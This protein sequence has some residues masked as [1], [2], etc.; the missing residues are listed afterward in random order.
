MHYFTTDRVDLAAALMTL[1]VMPTE[2]NGMG[3]MMDG[4]R[5][6]CVFNFDAAAKACNGMNPGEI[7]GLWCNWQ[8]FK[9]WEA[10]NPE[11]PL[12]YLRVASHN[13][14]RV[15]DWVKQSKLTH[16]IRKPDGKVFLVT[17]K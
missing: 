14:E 15:L 11:D 2:G 9:E 17:E 12:A 3:R 4:G 5:E 10:K 16:V 13:R 7:G 1:G 6:T 8:A